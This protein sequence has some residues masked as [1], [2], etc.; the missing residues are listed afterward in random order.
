MAQQWYCRISGK[1]YGPLSPKQLKQLAVQGKLKPDDGVRRESDKQW[2]P[3]NK[4]KGLFSEGPESK[5]AAATPRTASA[6]AETSPPKSTSKPKKARPA[7]RLPTAK[8]LEPAKA[9]PS[10]SEQDEDD[11]IQLAPPEPATTPSAPSPTPARPAPAARA[12]IPTAASQAYQEVPARPTLSQDGLNYVRVMGTAVT[13][14]AIGFATIC[15]AKLPILPLMVGTLGIL[16][17]LRSGFMSKMDR[18]ALGL[19]FV[20]VVLSI[21]GLAWGLRST[22]ADPQPVL[23]LREVFGLVPP[24]VEQTLEAKREIGKLGN[25]DVGVSEVYI[26]TVPGVSNSKYYVV[27]GLRLKND[28]S[29]AIDYQSWSI[30]ENGATLRDIDGNL[31]GI[32][33]NDRIKGQQRARSI[34]PGSQVKDV[35]VFEDPTDFTRNEYLTLSLSGRAIG[36]PGK[37]VFEVPYSVDD[38][39]GT[40]PEDLKKQDDAKADKPSTTTVEVSGEDEAAIQE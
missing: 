12:T 36:A 34:S 9:E 39:I 11:E 13:G 28:S 1:Q 4:V 18:N 33:T 5:E 30:A 14:V 23:T 6:A 24:P 29:E 25:L 27:I 3:A 10:V 2:A 17:A 8:S 35:L 20:A 22:L 26:G 7:E 37:V 40:A 21:S 38:F 31:C 16:F 15:L 32:V 19:S